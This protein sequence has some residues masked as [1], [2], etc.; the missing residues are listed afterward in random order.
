M[1]LRLPAVLLPLC[2]L[3]HPAPS[4]V[5]SFVAPLVRG[6]EGLEDLLDE[7]VGLRCDAFIPSVAT[8]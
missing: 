2:H 5:C 7:E 4:L 1:P 3:A 8:S 6:M